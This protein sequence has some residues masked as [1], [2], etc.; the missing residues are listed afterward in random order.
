[1]DRRTFLALTTFSGL[2]RLAGAVQPSPDTVWVAYLNAGV[3][4]TLRI[5]LSWADSPIFELRIYRCLPDGVMPL[6]GLQAAGVRASVLSSGVYLI[7][8]ADLSERA[9]AW[10]RVNSRPGRAPA[11]EG[12]KF[13]L[14]RRL[15]A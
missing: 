6:A 5:P 1:V 2:S 12:Y 15:P 10:T 8:W 3:P 7:P 4:D 14:Y 13:G 11:P 9:G